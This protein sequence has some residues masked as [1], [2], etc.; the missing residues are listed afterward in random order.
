MKI[1]GVDRLGSIGFVGER[2]A[3]ALLALGFF[4][5]LYFLITMSAR[6]ELPEWLALFA[7]MTGL[8]IV[9]F[10]AVGAEWFWGRWFGVGL[11]TW[12]VTL[13]IF[14]CVS[15]QS[16]PPALVIF[17]GLHGLIAL[18]LA[19][20]KMAARFDAQPAWRERWKLD[21][22]GVIRVRKSVTRAASSLPAV[23]MFALAP[24]QGED[25]FGSGVLN[26]GLVTMSSLALV[27][28]FALLALRRTWA[29]LVL[30]GLGVA[31]AIK[32]LT[33][34][35]TLAVSF[36]YVDP[37]GWAHSNCM[38]T[39]VGVTG[40]GLLIAS[41]LPFVGPMLGFIRRR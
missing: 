30:G 18:C 23:I 5:T 37:A 29:L 16:L 7:T 41:S 34:T 35:T 14:A 31:F 2:K 6:T 28:V 25:A 13:A 15:T 10:M 26:V 20:E 8:Y 21:E 22:E 12:G 4:C 40:G 36:S 27:A 3:L 1:P 9:T 19:G 33:T 24:R 32:A 17:G 11:G 39:L 38:L